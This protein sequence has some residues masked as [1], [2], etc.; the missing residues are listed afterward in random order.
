M[1]DD[2][3]AFVG[4]D[5]MEELNFTQLASG[6]MVTFD[7]HPG[8]ILLVGVNSQDLLQNGEFVFTDSLDP[9]LLT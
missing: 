8:S 4:V 5:G 1:G 6:T 3:L 2:R 7:D 9:L